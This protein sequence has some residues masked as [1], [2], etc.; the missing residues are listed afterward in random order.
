MTFGWNERKLFDNFLSH[1]LML[2]RRNLLSLLVL[3][4]ENIRHSEAQGA[5]QVLRVNPP[6]RWKYR[7]GPEFRRT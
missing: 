5:G 1:R 7:L 3:E 4:N 6:K 2:H